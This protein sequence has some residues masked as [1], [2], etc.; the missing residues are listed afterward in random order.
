MPEN[1]LYGTPRQ[2]LTIINGF[3]NIITIKLIQWACTFLPKCAKLKKC[4][5]IPEPN[6]P[7]RS[8]QSCSACVLRCG[9][10]FTA[11]SP[12]YDRHF[13]SLG[14]RPILPIGIPP[15]RQAQTITCATYV[16]FADSGHDDASELHRH[17]GMRATSS[18]AWLNSPIFA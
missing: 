14:Q 11:G 3:C 18:Q 5:L 1:T 10:S 15:N 17:R 7:R 8:G 9:I 2:D 4:S 13:Q 6:R 16:L 12:T